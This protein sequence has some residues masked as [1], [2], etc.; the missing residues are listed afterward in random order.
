MLSASTPA[1]IRRARGESTNVHQNA[2]NINAIGAS[3]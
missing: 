1:A 3:T 2:A